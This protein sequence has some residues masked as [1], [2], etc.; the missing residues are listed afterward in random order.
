MAAQQRQQAQARVQR[1]RVSK[2]FDPGAA[3]FVDGNA[4][5]RDA[6]ARKQREGHAVYLDLPSQSAFERALD[7][8]LQ[9]IDGRIGQRRAQHRNQ[10]DDQDQRAF[11][12]AVSDRR[13]YA[14]PSSMSVKMPGSSSSTYVVSG[15]WRWITSRACAVTGS[16][17]HSSAMA[18]A[19]KTGW[20]RWPSKRGITSMV[21]GSRRRNSLAR[22]S[23]V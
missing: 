20:P 13:R 11:H 5:E 10:Q 6:G 8:E 14:S 12:R 4:I 15:M 1:I 21:R 23:T 17:R 7:R 18:R 22:R 3:V 16:A 9:G 19:A 2:R